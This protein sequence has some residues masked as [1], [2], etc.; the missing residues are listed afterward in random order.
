MVMARQ[1]IIP[2]PP[3][4]TDRRLPSP[5]LCGP[6]DEDEDAAAPPPPITSLP[7]TNLFRPNDIHSRE[8]MTKMLYYITVTP[9]ERPQTLKGRND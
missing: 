5:Q 2:C 4:R 8:K 1:P 7:R 9:F 6:R 3:R